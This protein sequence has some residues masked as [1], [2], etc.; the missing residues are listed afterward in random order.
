MYIGHVHS[1]T[2]AVGFMARVILG[3]SLPDCMNWIG[4]KKGRK[5]R[6]YVG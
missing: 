6:V 5:E 2:T 3:L 1:Q 4:K